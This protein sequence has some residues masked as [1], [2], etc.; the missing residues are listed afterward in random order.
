MADINFEKEVKVGELEFKDKGLK[1][2]SEK[3]KKQKVALFW[4]LNNYFLR[5]LD[6]NSSLLKSIL[7]SRTKIKFID[8]EIL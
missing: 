3:V 6:Y 5:I 4:M 1:R 8:D 7:L 2:L